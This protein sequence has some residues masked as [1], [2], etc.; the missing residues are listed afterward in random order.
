MTTTTTT[1]HMYRFNRNQLMIL[2]A[3]IFGLV[4][5]KRKVK[6]K[7]RKLR[8]LHKENERFTDNTNYFSQRLRNKLRYLNLCYGFC[9]GHK[10]LEIESKTGTPAD[11]EKLYECYKHFFPNHGSCHVKS[12]DSF[13]EWILG[14]KEFFHNMVC[15]YL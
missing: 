10:Y 13:K 3:T 12:P 9:R 6:E 1:G 2:R 5:K 15:V 8:G 7:G 11:A 14:E 4:D